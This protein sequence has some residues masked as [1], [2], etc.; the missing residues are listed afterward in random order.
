MY[1]WRIEL[2]LSSP[3]VRL[4]LM[5]RQKLHQLVT[6]LFGASRKD[7]GL[8]YRYKTAGTKVLLY[9][10]SSVPLDE[11]RLSGDV[12]MTGERD[13]S[14]WLAG[15]GNGQI[16]RF[17]LLTMP[18]K[19]VFDGTNK[20]SRRRLLRDPEERL[21]WLQRKAEQN[22]FSVL[23]V[24]E[25]PA[26]RIFGSHSAEKGGRLYLD[27]WRYTGTLRITDEDL[28]R[29]AV[30]NGIGPDKAYGLGMLLLA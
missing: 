18:F 21:A 2:D 4:S 6:G 1:L 27:S 13:V 29:T 15:M 10:Y 28:F 24:R 22:G 16:L 26:E 3:R 14:A 19:K 17:D 5:D 23:S 8:L 9:I 7:A 30:Q 11:S 12:R 25:D 20:N